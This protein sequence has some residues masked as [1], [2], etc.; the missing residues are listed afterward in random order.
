MIKAVV[1]D[2][3]NVLLEWHPTRLFDA[4][5]GEDRRKRLFAEVDLHGMNLNVDRGAPFKE[6]VFAM[7]DAHP[8]WAAEIRLWHDRWLDM[9]SPAIPHS[10]RLMSALQAAGVP[11]FSLTNFGVETY[12]FA[13]GHYPFL[14]QFDRDFISGHLKVIKPEAKIY[15][16]LEEESGLSGAD[17]LFTDDSPKNIKAAAGRGWNTHLFEGPQG[18]ADRLVSEGLLTP[19]AAA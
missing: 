17:L 9:A 14:T 16:I 7:A 19:E 4:E 6:T 5:I 13:A 18:W 11:V 1:F 10:V 12:D 8:E 3:G 15:E 2:V